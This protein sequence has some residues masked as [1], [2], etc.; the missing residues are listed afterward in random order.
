MYLTDYHSH[1]LCSPDSTAPLA[2]MV[3]SAAAAGLRE[4]CTTD[5]L[6]LLD[7]DGAPR[8]TFDWAPILA[9]FQTVLPTCPPQLKLRLGLELGCGHLDPDFSRQ[10]LSGAPLDYVIGSVHNARPDRGGRD[11][12]LMDH[13]APDQA[14]AILGDYLDDLL[15]LA[16]LPIYDCLGHVIYPLRYIPH[17]GTE[18]LTTHFLDQLTAVLACAIAHD[19]GIEVN[20]NRGRDVACWGPI[21]SLYRDLGGELV[22]IGCDAHVPEHVALGVAPAQ[23]LLLESG[24]RYLTVYQQRTPQFIKL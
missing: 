1:S 24:F 7:I 17:L 12:A 14:M 2:D 22:T 5:H 9:Q 8:R 23:Q 3:S 19:R 16:P 6:D 10:V 11:L 13:R 18:V 15:A 21:L 20:T 4:F